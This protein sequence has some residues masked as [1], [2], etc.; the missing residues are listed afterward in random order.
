M[1]FPTAPARSLALA[2][3]AAL[4]FLAEA[5]PAC[6]AEPAG[7]AALPQNTPTPTPPAD[8]ATQAKRIAEL[9][10]QLQ[11]L[12][13]EL[14][15]SNARLAELEKSLV[16]EQA[17]S[18]SLT[19]ALARGFPSGGPGVAPP[20]LPQNVTADQALL[21]VIH[22]LQFSRDAYLKEF[23]KPAPGTP[24]AKDPAK[25]SDTIPP[26]ALERWAGMMTRDW[27]KPIRWLVRPLRVETQGAGL[28]VKAI[29]VDDV[30]GD[31]IGKEFEFTVEP[32]IARRYQERYSKI[33][34]PDRFV[35]AGV[36]T[37]RFVVN[38]DRTDVG[39]FDNPPFVGPGIEVFPE[40]TVSSF[41]AA[42][43]AKDEKPEAGAAPATPPATPPAI[44]P[45]T[46]P[47]SGPATSKP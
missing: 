46:P 19:E 2:V 20:D 35:V 18:K 41:V 39:A 13:A 5:V 9:E 32:R 26:R 6:N 36:F 3:V 16:A 25:S 45:A 15:A 4:P 42:K 14:A 12:L 31:A 1:P 33:T 34:P 21:S 10:S 8:P 43:E 27:R 38:L 24:E 44:P 47:A 40:I 23:A 11:K 37:P 28:F 7:H 30:T 17:K 29:V 22:F